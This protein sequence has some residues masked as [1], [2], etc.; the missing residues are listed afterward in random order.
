[1]VHKASLLT[2]TSDPRIFKL[3]DLAQPI[4]KSGTSIFV[5]SKTHAIRLLKILS[6]F[7]ELLDLLIHTG[8]KFTLLPW[9]AWQK[10][11]HGIHPALFF[12]RSHETKSEDCF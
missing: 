4:Q 12:F 1:M 3:L 9:M 7:I 10:S 2:V 11:F 6:N 8:S 5:N